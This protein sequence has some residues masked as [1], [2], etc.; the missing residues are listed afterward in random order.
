V[1]CPAPVRVSSG[2]ADPAVEQSIAGTASPAPPG[3]W[4]FTVLYDEVG[5][6]PLGLY[7][8][9][10]PERS[11][12]HIGLAQRL[13][14]VWVDCVK[15]NRYDPDLGTGNGPHWFKVHWANKRKSE[16]TFDSSPSDPAQGW[17]YAYYLRPNGTNGHVPACK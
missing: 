8:R 10:S 11:G 16:A 17:A 7:I 5:G 3:P 13:T 4:A 2:P 6:K 14:T 1:N 15:T 9:S 12:F